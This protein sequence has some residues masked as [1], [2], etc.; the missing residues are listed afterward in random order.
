MLAGL[1]IPPLAREAGPA[2][3]GAIRAFFAELAEGWRFLRGKAPLFQNTLISAVAQTSVGATIALTVVYSR[4]WLDGSIIPYPENWAA[5]ETAIGVGNLIGGFA[6]GAIGS[7]W[8]KGWLVVAGYVV[9]GVGTVV[10]GLATNV[11]IALVAALAMGVA[12]LVFIVPT[13]TLFA[14][15]TPIELMGRVVAFRGSFVFGS[16]TLAMAVSGLIAEVVPVGIVIAGFGAVTAVAGLVAALL[17]AIR[18]S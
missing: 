17:P 18:D 14:E 8:R 4:D 1:A 16:L 3:G 13:Q 2:V 5:I 9:M 7:R 15:L 10:L 6:V 12:N 11:L